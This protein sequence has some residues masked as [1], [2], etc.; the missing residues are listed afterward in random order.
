MGWKILYFPLTD[1]FAMHVRVG[2]IK[3]SHDS[4]C[5]SSSENSNDGY[6]NKNPN[7]REDSG[8]DEFRTLVAIS[9]RS[10]RNKRPPE[11]LLHALEESSS[12]KG[13]YASFFF[14]EN[15]KWRIFEFCKKFSSL[16]IRYNNIQE[17]VKKQP[18]TRYIV[19]L[20]TSVQGREYTLYSRL[21]TET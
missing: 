8:R 19:L 1:V 13:P 12:V 9:Y 21:L 20:I 5:E 3:C 14:W 10:H 11:T 4:I 2:R 15:N 6:T 7:N 17:N 18:V 16:N